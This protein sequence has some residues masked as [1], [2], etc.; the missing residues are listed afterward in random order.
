M[1]ESDA[2]TPTTFLDNLAKSV[3]GVKKI[4]I[5]DSHGAILAESS[6]PKNEKEEKIVRSF[7]TY[8]D[9]LGKLS[10]GNNKSIIVEC[11]DTSYVMCETESFFITFVCSKDANF[12]LLSEFPNDMSGFLT[13][14]R[15]YVDQM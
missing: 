8:N 6:A 11:N 7:P 5:S 3:H 12:S 10:Y 4:Y 13:Q 1:E 14:L 9:R 2:N 15:S